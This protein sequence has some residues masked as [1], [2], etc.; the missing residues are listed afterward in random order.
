MFHN[1]LQIT[2]KTRKKKR[3]K[4]KSNFTTDLLSSQDENKRKERSSH[5]DL[6]KRLREREKK[7]NKNEDRLRMLTE[8]FP[9]LGGF[10]GCGDPSPR[11]SSS[12]WPSE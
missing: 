7:N 1:F 5:T 4:T 11:G 8:N 2:K 10:S 12:S 9:N 3:S 6:S